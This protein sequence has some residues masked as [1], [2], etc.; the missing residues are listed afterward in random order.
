MTKES[1]GYLKGIAILMMVFLHLF[2]NL[3]N[4][5][6]LGYLLTIGD[7]PVIYYLTRMCNPVPFFLILSGYGLYST[8]IKTG[9]VKPWKRVSNLY[10][11][12][13]IIYFLLLPLAC[14]VRPEMYPGTVMTFIENATSWQ[15]SYIGEQWF[16]LPYIILMIASKW[17]FQ[18]FDKLKVVVVLVIS[19]VI[20]GCTL[21]VLK[22]YGESVLS[23]NMLLYNPFL[24]F[25]MMLPFTF[26]YVA[27]RYN[28][29]E[30]LKTEFD[31]IANVKSL[32]LLLLLWFCVI[33]CCISHAFVD[34]FYAIVFIL[35]FAL[36]SVA[37]VPALILSHLG[38]HSMNIWLIHTWFST[39]L[40]HD[41]IFNQIHYPIVMFVGLIIVSLAVSHLVEVIYEQ[42]NI[43]IDKL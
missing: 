33:R 3:Q 16:F 25:Y 42:I 41:F 13:W 1:S 31:K 23:N 8:Y 17:I 9:E 30:Y 14:W 20:Y 38:K 29:V 34:S 40:F 10:I 2:N 15:C 18:F 7:M 43:V 39:R 4:D 35:L 28:W 32:I 19:I 22:T 24:A 36:L 12:L 26:G 21:I 27:K 11:H 6:T 5:M 37:K